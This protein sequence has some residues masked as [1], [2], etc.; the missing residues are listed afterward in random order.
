MSTGARK[1]TNRQAAL[2]SQAPIRRA[3]SYMITPFYS[4][5][6]EGHHV[7]F[8]M[9]SMEAKVW[10]FTKEQMCAGTARD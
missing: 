1:T 3:A 2:H 8:T 10:A 6:N 5:W 4:K 7:T 9:N